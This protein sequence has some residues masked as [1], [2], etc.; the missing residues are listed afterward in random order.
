M[1]V[2]ISNGREDILNLKKV[3]NLPNGGLKRE[4]IKT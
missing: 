1:I 4:K 3:I 2:L